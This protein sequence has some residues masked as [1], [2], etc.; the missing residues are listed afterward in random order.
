MQ[1]FFCGKANLKNINQ[2]RSRK[3]PPC[4]R[5]FVIVLDSLGAAFGAAIKDAFFVVSV[6]QKRE[7][8]W[9]FS[10]FSSTLEEKGEMLLERPVFSFFS[11]LIMPLFYDKKFLRGRWFEE[12]SLGWTWC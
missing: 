12:S 4:N 3:I 10:T 6:K 9:R 5:V 11:K 8:C 7:F 1:S 2:E